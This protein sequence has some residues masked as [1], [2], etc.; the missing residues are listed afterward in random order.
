MHFLPKDSGCAHW[1]SLVV[2]QWNLARHAMCRV[3]Q[4]REAGSCCCHCCTRLT[5]NGCGA[6]QLG[7]GLTANTPTAWRA[8]HKQACL[9]ATWPV[10]TH[11]QCMTMHYGAPCVLGN[12]GHNRSCKTPG[13][14]ARQP[15]A[16]AAGLKPRTHLLLSRLVCLTAH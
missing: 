7:E 10:I 13:G 15:E 1:S 3:M 11:T 12:S 14:A 5:P 6:V 9:Q 2:F 4:A 8:T 16:V